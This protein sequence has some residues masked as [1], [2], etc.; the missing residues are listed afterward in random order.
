[1]WNR[2]LTAFLIL[3]SALAARAQGTPSFPAYVVQ[4]G[5]QGT[6]R[7]KGSDS[8]DPLVRLWIQEFQKIQTG[9]Q[10]SLAS[11]G[12]AT[13]PPALLKDEADLGHM[14]RAM[15]EAELEAFQAQFGYAPTGVTV[16]FDALAIY[17][18]RKNPIK[19][20]SIQELD[21]I[22]G[23]TRLT[24]A[25]KSIEGWWQFRLPKS[26][27]QRYWVRPYSRDENSG[28]RAFFLE[29]VLQKGGKLKETA[30]VKDQMG[31]MEVIAQDINAIGY[32]PESYRNPMVRMVPLIGLKA[33][34]ALLPTLENIQ[35]GRYALSRTLYIYLNQG[36]GRPAQPAV[37]AFLEFVLSGN[38]QDLA[39]GYGSAPLTPQMAVTE[40]AK[41]Q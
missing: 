1:M 38:G 40:L 34:T 26:A 20:L 10:F 30:R 31:I 16:A 2:L 7:L 35:S 15:N 3:G 37:K 22:Y 5:L 27:V 6:V 41:I 28:S 19:T 13:A 9:V 33:D 8:I 17:V 23:S 18:N 39:K 12:S 29:K 11:H 32:G 4:N 21:A 14:S 36:P 25:D 24:G